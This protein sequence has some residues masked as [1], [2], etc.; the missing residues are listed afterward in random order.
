MSREEGGCGGGGLCLGDF[1]GSDGEAG[2]GG[3]HAACEAE[4]GALA[5]V[6]SGDPARS[7]TRQL[8][9]Q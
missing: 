7:V 4:D 1:V 6:A 3:P 5:D 9:L 2:G 8:R